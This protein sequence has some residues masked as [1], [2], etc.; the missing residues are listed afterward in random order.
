MF[1]KYLDKIKV[2]ENFQKEDILNENFQ[3]YSDPEGKIKIYYVESRNIMANIFDYI[4]W[5]DISLEKVEF[6]EVDNLILSRLSYFPFDGI[7][8]KDEEIT[9][10]EAYARTKIMGTTGRTLQVED[11]DLYPLLAKSTRFGKCFITNFVN[12]VEPEQEKQFSGVTV[13]LPDGTIYVSFRGTDNTIVGWKEDFNMSFS[14]LVPSQIDS[15]EY[16]NNVAKKYKNMLRVG[17]HSKGGNLAVYAAA[18]SS[19]ETKKQIIEVY[20]NDGPGFSDKVIESK[21]YNEILKKVHTYIPQTSIIGRL[22]EHKEKTT[23]VKSTETGIMQHDLYS[24]QVLGDKFVRA[25]Q[26]NYS[27]FIDNTIT[28]W[29]KEVSPKQR[30]EFV[31]TWFNILNSTNVKTVNELSSK[32]FRNVG[33]MIKTYSNLSSETKRMMTKTLRAL[34]RVGKD[35]ITRK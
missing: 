34:L 28:N 19:D 30:E 22:L 12:K 35:N 23:I 17:G 33:T 7:I 24:W 9:L 29:L 27:D 18:F 10:K 5:R 1:E 8:S 31:D 25:K 20:N 15:V 6:N 3:L 2:L 21:E 16:L 14:D 4:K 13:I 26:T 11:I 32:W